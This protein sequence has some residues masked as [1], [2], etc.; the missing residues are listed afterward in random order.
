MKAKV[1]RRSEESESEQL[2]VLI[3]KIY[4]A[5]LDP[6]LWPFVMEGV[7]EF[8]GGFSANMFIHDS[9]MK[10]AQF[11]ASWGIE[12]G[13]WQAYVDKYERLNPAFPSMLLIDAGKII[14]SN[15]VVPDARLRESRF[16][17]E[18]LGPQ[19]FVDCVGAILEKSWTTLAAF[20]VFTNAQYG[21]VDEAARRR[22]ALIIPHIQRAVAIGRTLDLQSVANENFANTL[23]ALPAAVYLL[24]ASGAVLHANRSGIALRARDEILRA[25]G[26]RLRASD[27]LVD[28]EWQNL[29]AASPAGEGAIGP[30]GTVHALPSAGGE[31]WVAHVLPLTS[32]TRGRARNYHAASFAAF[33]R[34]SALQR[35]TLVEAVARRF[36]LTPAEL[37]VLFG[38]IEI[39]GVPEIAPVLGISEGTV[40]THL[41]RVFAKTG[42]NRQ[43]DLVRL[44]AEFANSPIL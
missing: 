44:V 29:F 30:T 7:C 43:A 11:L 1:H 13:F 20:V 21:P 2:S 27:P 28:G 39:G 6:S 19:G 37:R 3:G 4:D 12:G 15:D 40:K 42:T 36:A 8:V 38:V 9:A 17:K 5:A 10:S 26:D 35:P 33:V 41:K 23:D 34:E 24:D 14:T 32:A 25:S 22:M 31:R 18:W 16:F